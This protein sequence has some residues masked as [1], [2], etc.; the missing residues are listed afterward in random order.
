MDR[1]L[2]DTDQEFLPR[3]QNLSQHHNSFHPEP[4]SRLPLADP[5]TAI[6]D[7]FGNAD[8]EQD[9]ALGDLLGNSGGLGK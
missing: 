6:S 2:T 7:S 3:G 1:G 4:H 8:L 9:F 5:Q